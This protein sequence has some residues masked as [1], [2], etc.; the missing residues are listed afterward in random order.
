MIVRANSWNVV[1][2]AVKKTIAYCK[3]C[4]KETCHKRGRWGRYHCSLCGVENVCLRSHRKERRGLPPG[5]VVERTGDGQLNLYAA[6]PVVE[7]GQK[8]KKVMY[9]LKGEFPGDT[10]EGD[11]ERYAWETYAG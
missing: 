3:R 5:F 10:S 4:Q 9:Y 7:K 8:E 1:T 6:M 2:V 11:I